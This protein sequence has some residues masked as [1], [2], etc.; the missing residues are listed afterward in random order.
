MSNQL[1][2]HLDNIFKITKWECDAYD[3][4]A[5]VFIGD[6]IVTH[7]SWQQIHIDPRKPKEFY[8]D[9]VGKYAKLSL[10]K[11]FTD[12][13]QYYP[14]DDIIEDHR[15]HW[16][17]EDGMIGTLF[18]NTIDDKYHFISW[19]LNIICHMDQAPLIYKRILSYQV[20][21]TVFI[22]RMRFNMSL[23]IIQYLSASIQDLVS[24]LLREQNIEPTNEMVNE[25]VKT[26][27]FE[28]EE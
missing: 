24:I 22:P 23:Y 20:P 26:F 11:N 3:P 7:A 1:N 13:W 8:V 14:W 16:I 2:I 28:N 21:K 12:W 4:F 17:Y 18:F 9:I 25:I 27:H 15:D 19:N 5:E 10:I 6:M